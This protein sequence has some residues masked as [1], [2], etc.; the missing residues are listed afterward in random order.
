MLG[1]VK[2]FNEILCPIKCKDKDSNNRLS[3]E[4]SKKESKDR[5]PRPALLEEKP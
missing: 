5:D 3:K 2:G 1:I 4:E